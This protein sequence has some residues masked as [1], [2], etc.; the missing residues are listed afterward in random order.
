M[1]RLLRELMSDKINKILPELLDTYLDELKAEAE[2]VAHIAKFLEK[3]TAS[4]AELVGHLKSKIVELNG[5]PGDK[6]A[7]PSDD[8]AI[9]SEAEQKAV[10][11]H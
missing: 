10:R 5:K 3:S 9:D 11:T 2:T 4:R 8:R 6:V 7:G 1:P